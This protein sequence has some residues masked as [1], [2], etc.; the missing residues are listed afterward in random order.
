MRYADAIKI[1]LV[2]V[3]IRFD[4]HLFTWQFANY[5]VDEMF[6]LFLIPFLFTI[7]INAFSKHCVG[8]R[9]EKREKEG[10]ENSQLQNRDL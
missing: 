8:M 3:I 5:T 9:E 6:L 10:K 4:S 1:I 7:C 2:V